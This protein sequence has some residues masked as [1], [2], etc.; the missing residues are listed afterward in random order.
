MLGTQFPDLFAR[1]QPTVGDEPN[2]DLLPSLR[3]LPVLMW[4]NL[5]DELVNP[6]VYLQTAAKLA[7]LGYRY[8]LDAYQPCAN[9]ACSPLFPNHLE[10]AVNDQFAPAAAF[11]GSALVDRDPRSRHLRRR[12]GHRPTVAGDRRHPRLLGLRADPAQ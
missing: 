9:P 1:A 8:E 2:N 7:S 10:L 11:L 5:A 4:N 6:A 12:S 3:N